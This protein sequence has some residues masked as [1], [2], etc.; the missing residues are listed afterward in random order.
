MQ[1]EAGVVRRAI[2]SPMHRAT[3]QANSTRPSSAVRAIA[4]RGWGSRAARLPD[5]PIRF[6]THEPAAI[7]LPRKNSPAP[8]LSRYPYR[9]E[10]GSSPQPRRAG[11]PHC[12]DRVAR[13][14]TERVG[15]S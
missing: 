1:L 13:L 15:L 8:R 6:G 14:W 4:M 11:K 3:H 9:D 12:L 2:A 5:D 7:E 10:K